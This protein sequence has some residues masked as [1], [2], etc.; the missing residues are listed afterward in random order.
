MQGREGPGFPSNHARP[1]HLPVRLQRAGQLAW[2]YLD[3]LISVMIVV[4]NIYGPDLLGV[5]VQFWEM[6]IILL[7]C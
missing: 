2:L 5:E 3:V 6:A 4:P 1:K 7:F